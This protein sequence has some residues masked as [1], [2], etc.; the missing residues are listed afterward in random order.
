VQLGS[1]LELENGRKK[2]ENECG[3]RNTYSPKE[4]LEH[5]INRL[6]ELNRLTLM[7]LAKYLQLFSRPDISC[8][9]KM[10]ASNLATVFAPNCLRCPSQ[11]PI[12]ILENTR[13]EMAF[14][15]SIIVNLD[16]SSEALFDLY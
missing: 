15:K 9:T 3:D 14:V 11:D 5:L 10:D 6:P 8:I 4:H 12:V 2:D 1:K 7:Y 16:I 13:K